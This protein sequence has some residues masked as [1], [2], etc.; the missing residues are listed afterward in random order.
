M[1]TNHGNLQKTY[2]ISVFVPGILPVP[3]YLVVEIT[4]LISETYQKKTYFLSKTTKGI[5]ST[6]F[7]IQDV[8][9]IM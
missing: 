6:K 2:T 1:S 5:F 4:T 7:F 9:I 8:D 3:Q